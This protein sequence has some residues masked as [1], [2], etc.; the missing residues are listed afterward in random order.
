MNKNKRE[1]LKGLAIGSVW[2]TPV[3]TSVV[4]PVHAGTS[5]NIPPGCYRLSSESG[6]DTG[7]QSIDWEGGIGT[8]ASTTF[9]YLS[10]DCTGN[11]L[12]WIAN[13]VAVAGSAQDA[14]DAGIICV[15]L[16]FSSPDLPSGYNFYLCD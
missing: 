15:E 2:A 16:S 10:S 4:L 8:N 3:V 5:A 11:G 9:T 13:T 12:N 14:L 7:I 6:P 1:L